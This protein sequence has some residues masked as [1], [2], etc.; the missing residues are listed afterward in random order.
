MAKN[1]TKKIKKLKGIK[2]EK[3]TNEE[4]NK[5]QNTISTLNRTQM[6]IGS[7]QTNIHQLSHNVMDLNG[8]LSLMQVEFEKEYG[9]NDINI[10]DGTINYSKENV[11][12][13]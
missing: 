1:T 11:K 5:L 9:T 6:Q 8:Q 3:I 12:A 13:D 7:L 10:V 2:H 4:L